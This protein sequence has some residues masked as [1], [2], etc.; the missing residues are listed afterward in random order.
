MKLSFSTRGWASL[1][2]DEMV[3]EAAE[4][5]FSGIEPYNPMRCAALTEKGGP[6]HKYSVMPTWRALRE[7]GLSIPCLDSSCDLSEKAGQFNHRR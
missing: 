5:H 6:F 7:K 3:G 1:S 2:W 4:M